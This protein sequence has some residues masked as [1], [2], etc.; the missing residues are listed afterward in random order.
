MEPDIRNEQIEEILGKAPGSVVRWG[1]TVLFIFLALLLTGSFFFK[2]PENII[3]PVII[4]TINPPASMIARAD[5]KIT[6]LFVSDNSHVRKNDIL[7]VI[8]NPADYNRVLSVSSKLDSLNRMICEK[9]DSFLKLQFDND[10]QLGEIQTVYTAF[11]NAFNALQRFTEIGYYPKKTASVEEQIKMTRIY[12]NRLYEQKVLLEQD[13]KLSQKQYQRDSM[14][15]N[16]QVIADAD[17]EKSGSALLQKKHSFEGARTN[18][19]STMIQI[20]ELEQQKLDL[21]LQS[22]EQQKQLNSLLMQAYNNL[23]GE[24]T[25]WQQ[26]YLLIAPIEGKITFTK[27]WSLNQNVQTGET[28]LTIVPG[29]KS[30][31]IGRVSLQIEGSGKVKPGQHVNIKFS[32]FPYMEFGI[33]KGVV[34][35]ISLVPDD[36]AYTVEITLPDELNTNYGRT[37]AF[38][39]GM[40]GTAEIITDDL[41]LFERLVNPLRSLFLKHFRSN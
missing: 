40:T 17:I 37:L 28:V 12:Y 18:L 25:V 39:Q 6:R 32:N 9:N 21:N 8:E 33:V 27:Y 23:K 29:E 41:S 5:G 2:Y 13:L 16:K 30:E 1:I 31:L 14:L 10:N 11:L 38:S 36:K 34:K 15:L 4:T 24:I 7:A 22:E 19:A 26:K 20:S 3:S 35:S